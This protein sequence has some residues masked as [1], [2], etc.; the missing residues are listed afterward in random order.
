MS[1]LDGIDKLKSIEKCYDVMSITFKGVPIWPYVRIYLFQVL[2]QTNLTEAHKVEFSKVKTVLKALFAYNPFTLFRKHKTWLFT[3]SERRKA[4]DGKYIQRVSGFISDIDRNCLVIEKPCTNLPHPSKKN[5]V[6]KNVISEAHQLL[7]VH[8]LERFFRYRKINIENEDVIVNI[9]SAIGIT[10]DYK[11]YVRYM[12]SQKIVTDVLLHF[13]GKPQRVFVE[14]PYTILGYLWSFH[15]H[16]IKVI[17]LQHGVIGAS[18]Y[19]YILNHRSILS[20]DEIWVY[21]QRDVD[22]L[23][24]HN[25]NYACRIYDVGLYYLDYAYRAFDIDIFEKYRHKYKYVVVFAGQDA[26]VSIA[27]QFIG[28]VAKN[29]A[30]ILFVYVPRRSNETFNVDCSNVLFAPDVNIY[31]YLKW[32]DYH[33]TVSSTT[34]LE[35]AYYGK[36]TI[37]Y[38]YENLALSYYGDSLKE[39]E[40]VRYISNAS[41]FRQAIELLTNESIKSNCF[42]NF[43][44]ELVTKLLSK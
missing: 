18:H 25:P 16:N 19:A 27:Q 32:C 11:Y 2:G 40:G 39:G 33:C 14:C 17:E 6:E 35:A 36:K 38:N 22:F 5:I 30:D 44:I 43:S 42:S 9:L 12:W 37:F 7:A 24:V 8:I 10:F 41:Q 28:D 15:K 20:P 21:G 4:I 13:S 3:S 31:Q 23:K 1:Y 26:V 34:C 29:N